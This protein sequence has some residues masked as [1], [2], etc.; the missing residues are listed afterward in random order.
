[1]RLGRGVVKEDGSVEGGDAK[2]GG[3]ENML[4]MCFVVEVAGTAAD[5]EGQRR[6]NGGPPL[7][8]R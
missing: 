5:G 1:M 7:F 8:F 4:E 6:R 2:E 3:G